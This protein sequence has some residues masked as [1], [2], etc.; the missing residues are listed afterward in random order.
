MDEK[1]Y[2]V[3]EEYDDYE[4]V[5]LPVRKDV[6][7]VMAPATTQQSKN[8]PAASAHK[9]QQSMLASFFGKKWSNF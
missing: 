9:Q 2:M 3:T 5:D 6:K 8:K 1:G 7:K 4:E